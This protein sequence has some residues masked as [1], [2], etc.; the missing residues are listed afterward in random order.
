MLLGQGHFQDRGSI[1]DAVPPMK[2][3][4]EIYQLSTAMVFA[5]GLETDLCI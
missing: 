5:K 2:D 1:P 4:L 3:S